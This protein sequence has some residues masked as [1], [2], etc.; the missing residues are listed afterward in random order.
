MSS[1]I[2]LKTRFLAIQVY[3]IQLVCCI[4]VFYS[5]VMD[6]FGGLETIRRP[7]DMVNGFVAQVH[8]YPNQRFSKDLGRCL[9]AQTDIYIL[10]SPG[11]W[12][13]LQKLIVSRRLAFASLW[14]QAYEPTILRPLHQGWKL[15]WWILYGVSAA[16]TAPGPQEEKGCIPVGAEADR[17]WKV[18]QSLRGWDGVPSQG[19]PQGETIKDC[20]THEPSTRFN[21]YHSPGWTI[22]RPGMPWSSTSRAWDP[23]VASR[24]QW[25]VQPDDAGG[26]AASDAWIKLMW[27]IVG[28]GWWGIVWTMKKTLLGEWNCYGGVLSL[29]TGY[30][31]LCYDIHFYIFF[32]PFVTEPVYMYIFMIS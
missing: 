19:L 13:C 8:G 7:V 18:R 5:E 20:Q 17:N 1:S 26:L 3:C 14:L 12:S 31:W 21:Q 22:I 28:M 29:C 15:C 27:S 11:Y 25:H 30:I 9:V 10:C 16:W 6:C 24:S 2:Q 32:Y 4:S 23:Q